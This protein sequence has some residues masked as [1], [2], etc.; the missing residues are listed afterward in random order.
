VYYFIYHKC[1]TSA[2]RSGLFRIC[3]RDIDYI[4]ISSGIYFGRFAFTGLQNF[5]IDQMAEIAA[6]SFWFVKS[7]I[8]LNNL[9]ALH[10]FYLL[11]AL[12]VVSRFYSAPDACRLHPPKF[13]HRWC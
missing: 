2:A 12:L 5:S 8:V 11:S 3:Y 10:R 1:I 4:P 7:F 13:L 6:S 9:C